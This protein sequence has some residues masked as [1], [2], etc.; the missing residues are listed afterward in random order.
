M[1]AQSG[2]ATVTIL[3]WSCSRQ[4][5]ENNN[6]KK[7]NSYAGSKKEKKKLSDD[8]SSHSTQCAWRCVLRS[9][10]NKTRGASVEPRR[11]SVSKRVRRYSTALSSPSFSR[12]IHSTGQSTLLQLDRLCFIELRLN[13]MNSNSFFFFR[14]G[15]LNHLNSVLWGSTE[16]TY[17]TSWA[18]KKKGNENT[19]KWWMIQ[20]DAK[21]RLLYAQSKNTLRDKIKHFSSVCCLLVF[22]HVNKGV[23]RKKK[24]EKLEILL[25]FAL[26]P[27]WSMSTF[28][29]PF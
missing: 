26:F 18:R 27:H 19:N 6:K 9:M 15:Y 4:E 16:C 23:R 22:F 28:L 13:T 7:K 29:L 17:N 5:K 25:F 8:Y 2:T 11:F 1:C 12:A 21:V 20:Q 3:A 24:Q 14:C 10:Q